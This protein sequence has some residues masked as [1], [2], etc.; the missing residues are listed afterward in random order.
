MDRFILTDRQEGG[1]R[2]AE[3]LKKQDISSKDLVVLALPRGGVVL[4]EEIA[5]LFKVS[6]DVLVV[7]KIGT[8]FNPELAIGAIAEGN[9]KVIDESAMARLR[10]SPMYLQTIIERESAE[11]A[12]RI[13]KYRSDRPLPNLSGKNVILVDDGLATGF[14]VSAAIKAVEKHKPSS[15]RV[16]S[17]I[18]SRRAA[19]TIKDLAELFCLYI[20]PEMSAI[21]A[22][23]QNFDQVTDQEVLEILARSRADR[24]N[25]EQVS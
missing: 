16:A 22:Y 14:T 12:R 18:C 5:K 6:F 1:Q 2:L 10:V 13:K 20:P 8:P 23:Y 24:N 9:V 21:G 3:E 7:R 19:H 4:A 17:P 11:L 25:Q 15:I